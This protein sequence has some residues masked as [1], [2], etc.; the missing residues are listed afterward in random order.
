MIIYPFPGKQTRCCES[1]HDQG[2]YYCFPI[3]VL[4]GISYLGFRPV[5]HPLS[6]LCRDPVDQDDNNSGRY[7]HV[8]AHTSFHAETRVVEYAVARRSSFKFKD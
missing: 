1:R 5:I 8:G 4:S 6:A 2:Q 3:M 7:H